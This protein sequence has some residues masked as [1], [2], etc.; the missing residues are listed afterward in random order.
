M[1][2][3]PEQFFIGVFDFFSIVLPGAL[4]TYLFKDNVGPPFFGDNYQKL[5]GTEG[6]LVFLFS[7][8]LVGHFVF[9]LGSWLLD[10][11]LYD[12]IRSA[13]Y[14]RQVRR[15]AKGE[16][17]SPIWARWLAARLFK[18]N[19][20]APVHQAEMIK[21]RHLDSLK[22]SSAINTFQWCKPRL[23]LDHSEAMAMVQRFEADSKFFRS[24]VIVL[25]VVIPWGLEAR[26]PQIAFACNFVG[27]GV[28][29][30]RGSAGKGHEPG[31]LVHHY[32]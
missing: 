16:R 29:E 2:F 31:L 10:D 11:H 9:L 12:P 3:A 24:F 17:L 26:R 8:Y 21:E 6:W 14:V 23:A 4:L 19:V 30:V 1:N 28:L 18:R 32:P 5:A 13:T 25:C 7:S 27:L 15:L 22:A 20:D